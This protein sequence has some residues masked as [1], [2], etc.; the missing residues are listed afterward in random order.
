M[1]HLLSIASL[2]CTLLLS[3]CAD[4]SR[5]RALG[6][7]KVSGQALAEHFPPEGPPKNQLPN[8]ILET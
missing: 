8:G 6:D 4:P 1:K 7:P 3:A 5:S 2:A